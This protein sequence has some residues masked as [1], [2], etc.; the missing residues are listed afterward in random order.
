MVFEEVGQT[1]IRWLG[2][3]RGGAKY[4]NVNSTLLYFFFIS[5]YQASEVYYLGPFHT[6]NKEQKLRW[7]AM[8]KFSSVLLILKLSPFIDYLLGEWTS[9]LLSEAYLRNTWEGMLMRSHCTRTITQFNLIS[10]LLPVT[11]NVFS[12]LKSR[13]ISTHKLIAE[14]M[15]FFST[16][17]CRTLMSVPFCFLFNVI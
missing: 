1:L 3:S 4:K 9:K 7:N 5:V 13:F 11:V 17:F 2:A 12:R 15:F 6:W 14:F 8:Y 16:W 10:Y